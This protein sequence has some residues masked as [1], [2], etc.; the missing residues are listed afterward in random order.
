[1]DKLKRLIAILQKLMEKEFF[2]HVNISF[3]KGVMMVIHVDETIKL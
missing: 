3:E 1:M 2:G